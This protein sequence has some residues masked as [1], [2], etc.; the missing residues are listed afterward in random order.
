MLPEYQKILFTVLAVFL[1]GILFWS[2][3]I[4]HSVPRLSKTEKELVQAEYTRLYCAGDIKEYQEYPLIWYDENGYVQEDCVWRYIGTY[5][6]CYA[7]LAI[8]INA[9]NPDFDTIEK[10]F[11]IEGLSREVL[12]HCEVVPH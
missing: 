1:V 2:F 7:L 11:P 3:F 10:P 12:Y 5:G 9:S 6:D 4:R 8:G